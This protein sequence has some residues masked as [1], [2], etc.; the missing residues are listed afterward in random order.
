MFSPSESATS[1]WPQ[2]SR[3]ICSRPPIRAAVAAQRDGRAAERVAVAVHGADEFGRA[4]AVADRVADL[5][6]EGR[7]VDVGDDGVRPEPAVEL[8]LR[9]GARPRLEEDLE[10]LERLGR[11]R[12]RP[13]VARERSALGVEED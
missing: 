8:G 11:D 4:R 12:D 13:A 7:K 2:I 6:D 1:R 9:E 5:G 3:K 10:Q